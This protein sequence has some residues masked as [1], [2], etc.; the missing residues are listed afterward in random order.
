MT[1]ALM[2]V[3]PRLPIELVK[4]EGSY[5]H[6]ADGRRIVDLYG[7]HAVSPLGHGHPE[8]GEA[9]IGAFRTVDF[10]SNSLNMSVQERAARAVL[11]DVPGGAA[12]AHLTRVH[13]VNAGT[14]ANEAA[15]HVARRL[16][17]RQKILSFDIGFHGRTLGSL[18]ATHLDHYAEL[19][20]LPM[21]AFYQP[22]RFGDFADLAK[23]DETVAGVLC[24]SIPSLGGL[25]NPP[26][27]YYAA[28]QAR[29]REVGAFFIL[30]EV[31]GGIGRTGTWFAH[32]GFGVEPDMVT[33]AK[34]LGGGFPVAA[35]VSTEAIASR[36][37]SGDL[38]T[39]F[40]GGPMA[41]AMVEAV[42]RIIHRDGLMARNVEMFAHLGRLL[43]DVP[44]VTLRGAGALIGLQGPMPAGKVRD[45]L[46]AR[47]FMVGT[48]GEPHT[49]RLLLPYVLP[50]HELDAFAAVY[51]EVVHG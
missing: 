35:M 18:A 25:L 20:P 8:L 38:G 51:R 13:F 26:E 2:P 6:L 40:G 46:L 45:A 15:I 22:I 4:A 36:L 29:C 10:Y 44:G 41:C 27:G 50:M 49:L 11:G 37:K 5:L 32:Q 19:L 9:L 21:G 30:D 3:Y 39:T 28:L 43:A 34:S 12:S 1:S 23:I 31:Q 16:T 48:S 17:G 33:L 24:E 7:G 47:G 14:E 42:A